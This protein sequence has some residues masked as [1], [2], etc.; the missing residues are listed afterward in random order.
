[1]RQLTGL[2]QDVDTWQGL[3]GRSEELR[4]LLELAQTDD[5]QS[6]GEEIATEVKALTTELDKLEFRLQLSGPHDS[7]DAILFIYAGAGGTESQDWA[8]MLLRM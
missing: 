2:K 6:L 5:D 1:M 7:K 8:E 3:S 4:D